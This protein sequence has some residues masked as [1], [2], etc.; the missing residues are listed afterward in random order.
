M[1]ASLKARGFSLP[2][3]L[4]SMLLMV[5]VITALGGYY[6]ALA[7]GGAQLN[8]YR[9]MWRYAWGQTQLQPPALPEGW[10]RQRAQTSSQRCVSINVTITT[11][12]GRQGRLSRLHC[13]VSQ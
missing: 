6:R 9:Q 10:Q 13:P 5:M 4:L 2:E 12:T 1:S 11:P 3:A 7:V 8:Q